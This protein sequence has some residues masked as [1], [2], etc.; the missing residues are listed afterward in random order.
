MKQQTQINNA[1]LF[2]LAHRLN[3][4]YDLGLLVDDGSEYFHMVP[5]R[6]LDFVYTPRNE[7]GEEVLTLT[8][9]CPDNQFESLALFRK[10]NQGMVRTYYL[11]TRPKDIN[12]HFTGKIIDAE[13]LENLTRSFVE[14]FI[15]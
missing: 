15:H 4:K 1:N 13:S 10:L 7:D 5:S 9:T 12:E 8:R 14:K 6:D 11:A 3:R 2:L